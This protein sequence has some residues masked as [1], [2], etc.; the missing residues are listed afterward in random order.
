MEEL[1]R[2]VRGK[3]EE[4]LAKVRDNE[5][6]ALACERLKEELNMVKGKCANLQRDVQLSQ[7][8]LQK[9]A[10]DNSAHSDSLSF[11]KDRVRNLEGDL[12]VAL[13]EKT[14]A[15]CEV[16]RL[17]Q[18]NEGLER[19]LQDAK[20]VQMR[21][22]GDQQTV[23]V[24][25]QRLQSQ[26]QGKQADVEVLLR[27]REELERLVK[28]VKAEALE[29]EK[30]SADYY[31]Q[32]LRTSENF[33]V[34]QSEQRLLSQELTAKQ[35]EAAKAERD[36]L[37]LERELLTLRPLKAQLANYSQSTQKQIEEA[38]RID[39]DRA[40]IGSKLTE[41]LNERDLARAELSE[42][43]VKHGSLV[44]QNQRLLEQLRGLE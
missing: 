20:M 9:V 34:L 26:L 6:L 14:D 18:A 13:R 5:G 28:E 1:T 23:S 17:S 2:E 29:A 25:A 43:S 42:L 8:Y 4:L 39:A 35:Q 12:E 31:Q 7:G 37:A 10:E 22:Q 41:A 11:L 30:K 40:R 15:I 32:L 36:R 33:Q 27:S 3:E 21:V 16:K 38:V 19:A 24:T 44:Q